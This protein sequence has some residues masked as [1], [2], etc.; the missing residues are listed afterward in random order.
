MEMQ[1]KVDGGSGK[2]EEEKEA[3]KKMQDRGAF[4]NPNGHFPA[5]R[6]ERGGPST[7]S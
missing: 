4:R 2:E 1:S 5:Y 7:M 6:D 3:E